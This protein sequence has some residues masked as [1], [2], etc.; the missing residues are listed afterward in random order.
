M[1]LAHLANELEAFPRVDIPFPSFFDFGE[2]PWLDER[3]ASDHDT[4]YACGVDFLP[5][6]LRGE[7]IPPTKDGNRSH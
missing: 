1:A 6:V 2:Y 7:A 3:A 4:V 5:V